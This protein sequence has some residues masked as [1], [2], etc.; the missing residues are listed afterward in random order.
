MKFYRNLLPRNSFWYFWGVSEQTFKY[1]SFHLNIT[2]QMNAIIANDDAVASNTLASGT[3][4]ASLL[5][6]I[7]VNSHP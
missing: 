7:V 4:V 5:A 1:H 6:S 2:L 3:M